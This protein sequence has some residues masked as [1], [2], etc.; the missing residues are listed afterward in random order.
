MAVAFCIEYPRIT[1]VELTGSGKKPRLKRVVVGDLPE[2]RNEDGTPVADKQA[3][4]NTQVAAFVKENKLAGGKTYLLAGPDAMRY[5]ELKLAFGDKRQIGRVLQFQV[6]GV[7][8]NIPIEQLTIGYNVLLN[9]PDGAR[10]LVHAANKEYIR[11]RIIALEEAGCSVEAADSNLSG[12]M[13]IGLIDPQFAPAMPAALWIDFAGTAATVAI[14]DH[15]EVQTARVF[16]SPYLAGA[17]GS[18]AASAEEAKDVAKKLQEQAESQISGLFDKDEEYVL[19]DKAPEDE[20]TLPKSESVNIGEAEVADRIRHMSRDELLKFVNRVA[21]EARRTL[22][23]STHDSEPQRLVVSG[24]GS[25]GEK[26]T[27]LLAN[28]LAI[29]DAIAIELMDNVNVPGRGIETPDVGELTYLCGVAMKGL[30]R[31]YTGIDFRY[32]D[33]AAGTLF[34]YAKTPLAFT[35]TLVLLFAGIMFLI[36]YTHA[37]YYERDIYALVD[38]DRGPRY[39]FEGAFNFYP[40][41]KPGTPIEQKERTYQV[42]E[43][44]AGAEIRLA[45][46]KLKDHQTR[47]QGG[48]QDI[49]AAPHPADQLV[50]EILK[51]IERAVPSYDFALLKLHVIESGVT[52]DYLASITENQAERDKLKAGK[53]VES[54]R[55]FESFRK[56]TADYP[57]WFDGPP[58]QSQA[59]RAP[60][61]PEGRQA[62]QM[63]LK[64]KLKKIEPPKPATAPKPGAK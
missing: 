35:A 23:I 55:M 31:D 50:A 56:L 54:E 41:D 38:H 24:L 62:D 61:G 19:M 13:N 52:V 8:P 10:L 4:L 40:K 45:H 63:S 64:L 3:Y 57:S 51:A 43:D 16:V 59:G 1:A 14:V 30:G 47:L 25:E 6:E 44:D 33:L 2:P 17:T 27:Q 26:L 11:Q 39:F 15:G 46:K 12:T 34:D 49:Y 21:I 58:E 29:E 22:M 32:G 36:S 18:T 42:I 37:Q 20:A 53:L 48:V 9:E 60:E 7:I 28:E 5:R